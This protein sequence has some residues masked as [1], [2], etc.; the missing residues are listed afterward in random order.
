VSKLPDDVALRLLLKRRPALLEQILANGHN[1]EAKA[2]HAICQYVE[3]LP[4]ALTLLRDLLQ[5]THLTL[6]YL[7]QQLRLRGALDITKEQDVTDA[8]L[9]SIFLMSWQ[10]V[11]NP[12]AQRLFK[13]ASFFLEATPIPLWLLA[14]TADLEGNTSIEPLG[15]ARLDLVRWSLIEELP[16]DAIRL[17]P[18]IREVARY[19]VVHDDKLDALLTAAQEHLTHEFTDV[20]RLEQRVLAE[21][22]WKCLE[23]V[24]EAVNYAQ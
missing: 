24:H 9:F 14:L 19:L 1:Q 7:D 11:H 5:D 22:Y 15:N 23:H 8:R 18:I 4:L 2:A 12:D 17:H 21:G 6:V 20:N 13:L 3:C 16:N 10:N